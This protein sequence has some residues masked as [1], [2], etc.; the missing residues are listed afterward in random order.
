M[1]VV[2]K[3]GY[4]GGYEFIACRK[5]SGTKDSVRVNFSSEFKALRCT[6]CNENGLEPCPGCKEGVDGGDMWNA[7]EL[8]RWRE[9]QEHERKEEEEKRKAEKRERI[10]REALEAEFQKQLK[11]EREQADRQRMKEEKKK[12]KVREEA[13]LRRV[14][15]DIEEGME[16]ERKW[17]EERKSLV[18]SDSS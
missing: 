6:H 16:Q 13:I 1:K 10:K 5:C 7:K 14:V 4:C 3:C 12:K 9:S 8:E 18:E 11:K 15:N 17:R 2:E